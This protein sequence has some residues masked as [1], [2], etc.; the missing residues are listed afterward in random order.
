MHLLSIL[1]LSEFSINKKRNFRDLNNEM[2]H[3]ICL[4]A[5]EK[6]QTFIL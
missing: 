6:K 1:K 3:K 4:K 5:T 2:L